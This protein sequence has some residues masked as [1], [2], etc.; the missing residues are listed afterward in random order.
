M[1]QGTG[2]R[3]VCPI[4]LQH[5]WRISFSAG[6]CLVRFPEFSVADGLGPSDRRES[7]T[8]GVD[9]CLDLFSVAA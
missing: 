1:I 6:C 8:A 5:L 9:E 2:F 3:R 4:H 7:S